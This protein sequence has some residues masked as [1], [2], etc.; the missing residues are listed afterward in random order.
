MERSDFKSPLFYYIKIHDE[1]RIK[2]LKEISKEGIEKLIKAG[3]IKNS[4]K[5]FVNPKKHCTVGYYKT[6]HGRHRYIEDFYANVAEKL[7]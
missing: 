6:L 7:K 3:Y 1:R 4:G 5:G 2:K